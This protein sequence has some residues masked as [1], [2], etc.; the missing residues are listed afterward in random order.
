M[1]RFFVHLHCVPARPVTKDAPTPAIRLSGKSMGIIAMIALVPWVL[2]AFYVFH[3][4]NPSA[5]PPPPPAALSA[6]SSDILHCHPGPWGD[7][8]YTYILTEPPEDQLTVRWPQIDHVTWRFPHYDKAKLNALWQRANL[9]P[10]ELTVI[11]NPDLLQQQDDEIQINA[12]REFVFG[13]TPDA[14]A[15]IYGALAVFTENPSQN[16]PFRFR[17][18]RRDEWFEDSGLKPET[19]TAVKALLYQRGGSLRFSD[20]QL[21]LPT[22]M[23][24]AERLLLIKTLARKSTMIVTLHVHP[25]SDIDSLSEYWSMGSRSKDIKPLL[26]SLQRKRREMT[27]DITHLLPRFARARLY[28]YP[29]P[30]EPGSNSFMDCHWSSLN[31]FKRQPD[32]K[33]EDIRAVVDELISNYHLVSSPPRIGDLLLFTQ[34]NGDVIHSCVYIADEI[35]FTKNGATSK[36]PWILMTLDDV[37]SAYTSDQPLDIQR[38]RRKVDDSQ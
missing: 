13:L 6:A 20:Q 14:R 10:S 33:Y 1:L 16:E 9:S 27:L 24:S 5:N 18:S 15:I 34:A 11:T 2:V 38:Y 25:D 8:T 26:Q 32:P 21:L 7:L 37:V 12:P 17:S 31:F 30:D 36:A 23:S 28:T 29:S 35:V 22:I 3:D 4:R 19:I